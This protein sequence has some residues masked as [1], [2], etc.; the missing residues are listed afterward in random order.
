LGYAPGDFIAVDS[1]YISLALDYGVIGLA[2]YVAIFAIVIGSAVTVMLRAAPT[3]DREVGLLIPLATC[4]CS[5][6]VIRG[7]FQ[8]PDIHPMIFMLMGMV[9]ALVARTKAQEVE[10]SPVVPT[11]KGI[12]KRTRAA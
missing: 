7:V 9:L 6:L 8:Q 11:G 4:L 3:E 5:F 1:Y 2:L 10:A 12:T